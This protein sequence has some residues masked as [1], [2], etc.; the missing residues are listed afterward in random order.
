MNVLI[1]HAWYSWVWLLRVRFH[2]RLVWDI[3]LSATT[4]I[5]KAFLLTCSYSKH[6]L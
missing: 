3:F 4:V 2:Q 6:V 5:R 1:V